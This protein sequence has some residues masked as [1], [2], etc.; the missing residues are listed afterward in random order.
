MMVRSPSLGVS[1]T[2]TAAY[3]SWCPCAE[4]RGSEEALPMVFALITAWHKS[5]GNAERSRDAAFS[6]RS[7]ASDG[8]YFSE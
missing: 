6:T 4:D 1:G 2:S 5:S 3:V 8:G 7:R